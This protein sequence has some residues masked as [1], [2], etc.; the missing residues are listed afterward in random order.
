MDVS[1]AFPLSFDDINGISAGSTTMTEQSLEV[2]GLWVREL[3][4]AWTF[5][6]FLGFFVRD[7]GMKGIIGGRLLV[8]VAA[9]TKLEDWNI[10]EQSQRSKESCY[11]ERSSHWLG[12]LPAS[13]TPLEHKN[14]RYNDA[15]FSSCSNSCHYYRDYSVINLGLWRYIFATSDTR[16]WYRPINVVSC[17]TVKFILHRVFHALNP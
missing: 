1:L 14:T 2:S 17:G 3:P 9:R 6:S 13:S 7:L 8:L 15:W 12:P 16:I 4:L 10:E 11:I 5:G